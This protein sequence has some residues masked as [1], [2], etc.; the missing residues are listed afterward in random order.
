MATGT[1]KKDFTIKINSFTKS[2]T[3][4][5]GGAVNIN[6]EV[7]SGAIPFLISITNSTEYFGVPFK[8]QDQTWFFNLLDYKTMAPVK[9]TSYSAVIYYL[10]EA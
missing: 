2:G 10:Y 9:N 3:S 1:I 6:G 4:N 8:Q 7:P 5:S